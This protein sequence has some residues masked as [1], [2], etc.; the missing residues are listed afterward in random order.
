MKYYEMRTYTIQPGK[1][2][3]Y[4]KHF[5]DVGVP[6][7][8]KYAKLVGFW[9]TDIGTLNQV[10]H[11]WEYESLDDRT[12]RRRALYNDVDWREKFLPQAVPMIVDQKNH[13]MLAS[14]FSPIR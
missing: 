8:T 7:I 9:H 12:E 5:G 14:D 4:L 13:I 1:L 11:I 2:N 3:A 6:I 10:I